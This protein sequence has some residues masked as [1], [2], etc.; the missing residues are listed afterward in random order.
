MN[1]TTIYLV[2]QWWWVEVRNFFNHPIDRI[3]LLFGDIYICVVS[4]SIGLE[5]SQELI[6]AIIFFI[7]FIFLSILLIY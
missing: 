5:F 6:N 4:S 1:S 3:I 7:F 2:V